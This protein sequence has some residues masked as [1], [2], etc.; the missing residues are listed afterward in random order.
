MMAFIHENSCECTKS[1]LDI[2]SVPDTQTSVESGTYVEYR[3]VSTLTDGSPIEFD[4]AS[5]RD[6]YIDFA[7][8]YLYVKA[9]L[10][11]ADGANMAAADTVG[12][13]N[14]FLHSLFSEVDVSLNGTLITNST[15]TYPYRAY[16]ENL[17]S[18]GPAA[19]K[20]QLTACLFY[21]DDAGKM[22][23]AN[24]L[25]DDDDEK[26]SGLTQR[27]VFTSRSREVDLIGRIHS[28]IFFQSRYL[29]NEVNTKIKLTRSRDAFCIM[30][31][32][33][34]AFKV[35]ITAAA[36]IIRKVK[37][38]PSVYLAHAK[39]LETGMAKY[40]IRRVICKAYTI[41]TGYL[42]ASQEKLFSGQLPA[43]LVIGCVDN[44]AFN[45]DVARNPFN[46]QHFAMSELAVY[47]DGQQHGIKPLSQ[48]FE[49][50]QYVTSFMSLLNGTGKENRDEGNDIDRSDF[51][52]G[53]ALY[54]FDLSPDLCEGDHFNLARQGTVRLDMKFAAALPHTVTVVAYAEFENLIDI[55][56]NRNVVF[57]FNN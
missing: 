57:D 53:Y 32:G 39:T 29:L 49:N 21:K 51:A 45:G 26:N 36:M 38:S 31:V 4:I 48:N 9:K 33:D 14:N 50:N 40:P 7:N 24:P 27:A 18:Y 3:P 43:R 6:D 23:Q 10:V 25:A 8:S 41:P 12:P 37:V 28:D 55:D 46:F 17:L 2:F 11:R 30:A 16:I 52:N 42:D 54:A 56:R 19:K 1:E 47:L 13:V 22:D 20:S 5:S 44:R 34:Q 15:N 35:K